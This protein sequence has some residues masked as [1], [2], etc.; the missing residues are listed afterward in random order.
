MTSRSSSL[1]SAVRRPTPVPPTCHAGLDA[2]SSSP[3]RCQLARGSAA[4]RFER[5]EDVEGLSGKQDDGS[6]R[7]QEARFAVMHTIKGQDPETCAVLK[8][9]GRETYICLFDSAA[10]LSGRKG[11]SEFVARTSRLL[12]CTQRGVVLTQG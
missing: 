4:L 11:V 6:S 10:V 2:S 8:D 7:R 5:E 12:S 3:Q 1:Y 9:S